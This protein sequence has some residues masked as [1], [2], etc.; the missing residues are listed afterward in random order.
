MRKLFVLLGAAALVVSAAVPAGAGTIENSTISVTVGALPPIA[1]IQ[2]PNPATVTTVGG[3]TIIQAGGTFSTATAL[4]LSLFTGVPFISGFSATVANGAGTFTPA[5]GLNGGFGGSAGLSGNAFAN[6]LQL[7]PLTIPL[8]VIGAGG[9][10]MAGAGAVQVTVVGDIWTTGNVVVTGI[11]AADD[12]GGNV[13]TISLAGSDNRDAGGIGTV[14]LVTQ[15]LALTN[16][17]GNLGGFVV[18]TLNFIPE[19]GTLLLL[20]SGVIGLAALGRK[21]ARK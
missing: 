5:G 3:V 15:L 21:R 7:F 16:V 17:A 12:A 9:S 1:T 14:T 2:D 6:I 8:N 10:V 11:T 18:M 4:P 19:P 20:G 13:N